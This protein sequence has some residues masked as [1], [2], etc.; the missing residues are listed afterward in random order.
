MADPQLSAQHFRPHSWTDT[1]VWRRIN[2]RR[3]P[4]SVQLFAGPSPK[5]AST[6]ALVKDAEAQDTAPSVHEYSGHA[7]SSIRDE[8][9]TLACC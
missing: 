1:A 4:V 8:V 7:L 9:Q 6:F 5:H 2:L 3:Q